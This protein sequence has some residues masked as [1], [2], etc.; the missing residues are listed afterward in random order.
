MYT[1]ELLE[2]KYKAQRRLS[3]EAQISKTDYIEIVNKEVRDLFSTF[4]KCHF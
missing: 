3:K 4:V 1:S 2:E